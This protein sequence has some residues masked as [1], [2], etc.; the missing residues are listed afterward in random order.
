MA[1]RISIDDFVEHAGCRHGI[2]AS[3]KTAV[4]DWFTPARI[5]SLRTALTTAVPSVTWTN[6]RIAKA[7]R[8]TAEDLL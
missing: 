1:D 3:V 7:V 4:R 6:A 5:E 8:A 2:E